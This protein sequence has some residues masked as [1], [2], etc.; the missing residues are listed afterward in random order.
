MDENR[1]ISD[2]L[3][4]PDDLAEYFRSCRATGDLALVESALRDVPDWATYQD[5]RGALNAAGLRVA[6]RPLSVDDARST[7]Y[8]ERRRGPRTH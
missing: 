1:R 8:V 3:R 5:V 6:V 4:S 2:Y 7:G